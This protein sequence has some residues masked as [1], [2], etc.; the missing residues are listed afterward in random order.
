MQYFCSCR[1]CKINHGGGKWLST[2]KTYKK[3]QN[4]ERAR[5]KKNDESAPESSSESISSCNVAKKRKIE[6]EMSS[7]SSFSD[8]N[9]SILEDISRQLIEY[10]VKI[11]FTYFTN[12]CYCCYND[13]LVTAIIKALMF[14]FF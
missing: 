2:K 8:N 6:E 1:T 13:I 4:K 14:H 11:T 9:D 3:H 5:I 7:E 10:K 12:Y